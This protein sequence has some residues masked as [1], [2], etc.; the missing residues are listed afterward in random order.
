MDTRETG[1]TGAADA[2]DME[3]ADLGGS[4][5]KQPRTCR[6]LTLPLPLS[7]GVEPMEHHQPRE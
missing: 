5:E 3:G 6:L 7:S 4:W 2:G 1:G